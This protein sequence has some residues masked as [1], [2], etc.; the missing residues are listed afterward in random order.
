MR[1]V[2]RSP[3]CDGRY[4][5]A[6]MEAKPAFMYTSRAVATRRAHLLH[7]QTSITVRVCHSATGAQ[8]AADLYRIGNSI[9]AESGNAEPGGRELS[10]RWLPGL[11]TV[12]QCSWTGA[13]WCGAV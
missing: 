10:Q 12:A 9:V 6:G 8:A 1:Y 5:V 2:T 4:V 7:G 13:H 3:A 11:S